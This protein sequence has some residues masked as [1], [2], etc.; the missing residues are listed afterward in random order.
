[1]EDGSPPY[2]RDSGES[3][4]RPNGHATLYRLDSNQSHASIF[5]DVEMAHEEVTLLNSWLQ[6]SS[7][8]F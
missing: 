6:S 5:E 8:Q 2:T 3:L 1:M 4:A 7:M